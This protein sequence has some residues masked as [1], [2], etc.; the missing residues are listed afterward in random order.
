MQ[1]KAVNQKIAAFWAADCAEHI[2]HS[3]EQKYPK[4]DRPRKALEACRAGWNKCRGSQKSSIRCPCSCPRNSDQA[5][6]AAARAAG[7]A[8]ATAHMFGHA[9]HASTYAGSRLRMSLTLMVALYTMNE[10]G[11]TSV[12]LICK[13]E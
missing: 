4:D 2:L 13:D 8:V 6:H 9:I 3:Y 1:L 5:A 10:L 11:N 12:C 7:Q